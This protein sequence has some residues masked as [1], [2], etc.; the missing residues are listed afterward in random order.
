MTETG[1]SPFAAPLDTVRRVAMP[2]GCELNLR[3]AGPTVRVRAWLFDFAFRLLLFAAAA[4]VLGYFGRLGAAV[5]MLIAFL[6]EWFYPVFFEV[7]WHGATPGKKLSN[8]VV[9]HD[10]GT[11]IGWGASF[12]RNTLRVV[13]FLPF[14][15]ACGLLTLWLNANGKRLGDLIAGTV[16]VYRSEDRPPT[17]KDDFADAEPAP[18][19][20]TL[21]EQRAILEYRQ[22]AA[23]LTEA[24]A[25][26]LAE[27]ALPLTEGLRPEAAQRRL[28]RIGNALLGRHREDRSPKPGR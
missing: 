12:A 18:F 6:L 8:L 19:P 13:D 28:F 24:R 20:L 11:P 3:V 14:G 21:A 27:L 22:R 7:Y 16:V 9:L 25:H 10:D 4:M 5:A 2:E 26:E 23:T 17:I 1:S 15:Y